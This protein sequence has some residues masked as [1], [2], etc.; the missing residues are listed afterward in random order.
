MMSFSVPFRVFCGLIFPEVHRFCGAKFGNFRINQSLLTISANQ[1]SIVLV[2]A[3]SSVSGKL[4]C[5]VAG[6]F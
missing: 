1:P 4:L 2:R 5:G 6:E 3:A